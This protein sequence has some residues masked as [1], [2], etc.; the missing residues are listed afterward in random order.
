M[1]TWEGG[2][3]I[4]PGVGV[5]VE[6]EPGEAAWAGRGVQERELLRPGSCGA[7]VR[8]QE[9]PVLLGQGELKWE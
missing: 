5:W 6:T 4:S 1:I 2:R 8:S 3:E 9:R 7:C